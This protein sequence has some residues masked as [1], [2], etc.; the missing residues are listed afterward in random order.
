MVQLPGL[1]TPQC[2]WNMN[3]TGKH[4]MPVPPVF[5][6]EWPA[7]A[8]R[9]LA[10]HPRR[11]MGVG[12]S[13]AYTILGERIAPKLIDLYLDRT[14]VSSQQTDQELPRWGSNV[15]EP[16]DADADRGARGPFDDQA[17]NRDPQL[18][19]SMHRRSI[20][21]GLAAALTGARLAGR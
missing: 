17:H 8:I 6:P 15:D 18:W 14:G 9:F 1:N 16:Q 21:S 13:T 11:N 5:A 2:N 3:K 20:L 7:R 4:P 12:I 10:E 19:A